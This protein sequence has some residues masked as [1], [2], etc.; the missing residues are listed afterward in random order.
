MPRPSSMLSIETLSLQRPGNACR[1]GQRGHSEVRKRGTL[2]TKPVWLETSTISPH[3]PLLRTA[4]KDSH[5]LAVWLS[6]REELLKHMSPGP[7]GAPRETQEKLTFLAQ[8]FSTGEERQSASRAHWAMSGDVCGP[9]TGGAPG[10]EW[11]GAG[12]L[13][14]TQPRRP[15]PRTGPPREGPS[16][17]SALPRGHPAWAGPQV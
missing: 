8:G 15:V 11:V 9:M 3:G 12:R 1:Q 6:T 5:L 2:F 10:T 13:L 7:Y 4:P 17:V 16:P 14:N